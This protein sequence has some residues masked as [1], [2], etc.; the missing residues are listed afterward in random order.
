MDRQR[1]PNGTAEGKSSR[2]R[3]L[4]RSIPGYTAF[5]MHSIRLSLAAAACGLVL[6]LAP[7]ALAAP[8]EYQITGP[9]I[10]MT[11]TAIVMQK[12]KT[13]ETWEIARTADSK[14]FADVKVGDRVTVKYFMTA[15]SAELKPERAP[16]AAKGAAAAPAD[17]S[18]KPSAEASPSPAK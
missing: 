7:A 18:A 16:K 10:S 1:G 14:G 9:I 12:G 13:K 6:S 17:S 3:A 8:R 11:D 2:I 5:I 15:N 4:L